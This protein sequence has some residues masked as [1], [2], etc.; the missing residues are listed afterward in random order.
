MKLAQL[1]RYPVTWC[2]IWKGTSQDCIDHMR[3]AHNIPALV[4]AANLARWFPPWTVSK[5]QWTSIMLSVSGVA[6]DTLLFSRIGVPLFHRYR[7]FGPPGTHVAFRG[8]YMQ[9]I[10]T[11]LEGSDAAT[12]RAFHRHRTREIAAQMSRTTLQEAGDRELASSSRPS[13]YRRSGP[14]VRKSTPAAAVAVPSVTQR[15]VRS[16]RSSKRTIPALM[17]LALP[18]FACPEGQLA[19]PHLPW[20]V[21]TDSPASPAPVRLRAPLRSPSACLNLDILSLDESAGPGDVS[22]VPIC[23]SDASSPPGNPDQVL[24]DDDLPTAVRAADRQQYVRICHQ[25]FKWWTCRRMLGSAMRRRQYGWWSSR[26][27]FR[28]MIR[29]KQFASWTCL[30]RS[31]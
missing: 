27:I 29:S 15:V 16:H 30:R 19:R 8:R 10:R 13:M 5:E 2:N 23:I 28:V 14:W 9:R 21:M 3:K 1:W 31:G 18:K 17:D 26:Q 11:F 22:D 20:V 12:L 7:V 25:M 24:S 6:V 4:K